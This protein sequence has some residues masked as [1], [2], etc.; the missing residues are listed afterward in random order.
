MAYLCYSSIMSP[1][2]F[3]EQKDIRDNAV[4]KRLK[5]IRKAQIAYK[6]I[7]RVY[8][9]SFDS[10][11]DFVNNENISVVKKIGELSDF[12]LEK[13]LTDSIAVR[14]KPEDAAKYGV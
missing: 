2:E 9:A 11:M 6:D 14:L 12:Q 3:N 7:H 1:I 5:D 4:I 10:L 8:T 13:G